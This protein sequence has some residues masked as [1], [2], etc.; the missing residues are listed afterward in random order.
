MKK[1]LIRIILLGLLIFIGY[2]TFTTYQ[3]VKKVLAYRPM[4]QEVLD[5]ND[6]KTNEN[7][8]LAMIYTETKGREDDLMQ[9]SESSSGIANT[10][11][12]SR[13]SVKQGITVLSENLEEAQN[14]NTDVWTAVQ[15]YISVKIIFVILLS[16]V[17]RVQ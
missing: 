6:T 1:K 10:I 16:M 3:N 13:E 9:S 17:V 8:V 2:Q 7:L 12:D 14:R 15:A 4:V 11:T 5:E